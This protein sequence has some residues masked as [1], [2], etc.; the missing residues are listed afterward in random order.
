MR[1]LF[2]G[3]GTAGHVYPNIAIAE[4]FLKNDMTTK[5][6]YVVTVNGIENKLINFKKYTIDVQGFNKSL[7][8]SN[9][10][11]IRLLTE[12]ICESKRIINEFRPDIIVGT[13]GY[14][15][16]P[17]VYAGSKLGIKAVLHESN[18]VPGKAIKMLEKKVDKIFVNFEKSKEYFKNKD[19][20][21]ITGNPLRQ[22]Y[23]SIKKS[24][25]REQL[26]ICEKHV[27]LCFGGSLGATAVNNAAIEL[28]DNL[29]KYREDI[30]FI[31]GT[32]KKEYKKCIG[33]INKKG[34]SKLKNIRVLEYIDD[35]PKVLA[36]SDVVICRSGAMTVSEVSILGKCTVFIPSPNVTNNHQFKN[37]KAISDENGAFIITENVIYKLTDTVK[38]LLENSE[39]RHLMEKN[40]KKF[41]NIDANKTIYMEIL[42]LL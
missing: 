33:E 37:A 35:M 18:A 12:A 3:G 16:F 29:I 2:C 38:E 8:L 1:I 26:K 42:N 21:V 14:A 23:Y 22:E 13:G 4:T 32:G 30:L 28:I 36:S 40:I 27:V 31:W 6:A 15:T 20:V 34:L 19:K 9:F 11:K 17:V 7:S 5:L 10:K 41:S 24:Y 25:A 39:Q